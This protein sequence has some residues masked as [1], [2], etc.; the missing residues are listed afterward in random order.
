MGAAILFLCL[1]GDKRAAFQMGGAI[2]IAYYVSLA[3]F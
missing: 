2:L 3:V 1:A